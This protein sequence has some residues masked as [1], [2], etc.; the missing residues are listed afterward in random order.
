MKCSNES[1]SGLNCLD[2]LPSLRENLTSMLTG[3]VQSGE[4]FVYLG[5]SWKE[6]WL[7]RRGGGSMVVCQTVVLQPIVRIRRLPS[8]QLT[9]NLQVGCHLGWHLAAG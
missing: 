8:P 6:W 7:S 3:S 4:Y 9:A 1:N 5:E 2:L